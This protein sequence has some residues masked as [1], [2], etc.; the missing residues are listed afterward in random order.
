MARR[1]ARDRG[2]AYS[3]ARPARSSRPASSKNSVWP[4]KGN[5]SSAGIEDHQHDG[6]ARPARPSVSGSAAKSRRSDQEI[7]DQHRFFA[8]AQRDGRRQVVESRRCAALRR[9]APRRACRRCRAPR[10]PREAEPA[11]ALAGADA[12]SASASARISARSSLDWKRQRWRRNS[13][14]R[15]DRPRPTAPAPPPIRARAHRAGRRAPSGAN[16]HS[17]PPRPAMKGRNCQKFSPMPDAP[18]AVHAGLRRAAACRAASASAGRRR[19]RSSAWPR[20]CMIG[21]AAAAR[22]EGEAFA[23]IGRH[24]ANLC[25]S[26]SITA[27]M[28]SPSARA[29]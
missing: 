28:V 13:S 12:E 19:A 6:R 20:F 3:S 17:A 11:G 29:L 16:R 23:R 21:R 4:A 26:R 22:Q 18:A 15:T 1:A 24:Q 2:A 8:R 25:F 7:A 27:S 14:S 5:A 9:S 10:E